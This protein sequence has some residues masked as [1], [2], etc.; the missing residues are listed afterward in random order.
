MKT[1][2]TDVFLLSL[3][4]DLRAHFYVATRSSFFFISVRSVADEYCPA[5]QGLCSLCMCLLA[6]IVFIVLREKRK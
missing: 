2:D 3:Q 5:F 4:Q 6:V 1:P